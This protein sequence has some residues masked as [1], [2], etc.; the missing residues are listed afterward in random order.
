[1]STL[2]RRTFASLAFATAIAFGAGSAQAQAPKQITLDFAT[3]NPV[4]CS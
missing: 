4:S 3:Y 2:S 1:M